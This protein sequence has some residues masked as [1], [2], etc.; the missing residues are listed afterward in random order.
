M[1]FH[2]RSTAAGQT[3]ELYAGVDKFENEDLLKHA[4]A[5]DVWVHVDKLSS[6]HVYIRIDRSKDCAWT[7]KTLPPQVMMDAG[8]LVK[9]GSIAGNKKDNVTILFTPTS[10][11]LKDNSM[12][13]GAVS[14]HNPQMVHRFHVPTK[15][16]AIVNALTKTKQ[17]RTM[18]Q[19]ID[20]VQEMLKAEARRQKAEANE[21]K[22]AELQ[23]ARERKA[24][25]Q[26]RDYATLSAPVVTSTAEDEDAEWERRQKV[27]EFDPD[28]DFM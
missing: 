16:N 21:R 25:M 27:G 5:T 2:Y 10:N 1:V 13:T 9:A 20:Q 22:N 4:P 11:L 14:F 7:Y 24:Q 26:A 3:V 23:L 12:S 18:E 8:Q 19:F 15:E 28:E 17:T 6:P